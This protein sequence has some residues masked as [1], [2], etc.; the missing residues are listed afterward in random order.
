MHESN[1]PSDEHAGD[2][3]PPELELALAAAKEE[4]DAESHQGHK[5]G[6]DG[7]AGR[8]LNVPRLIGRRLEAEAKH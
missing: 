8:E 5:E 1:G 3:A 7:E 2:G 6:E 4:G